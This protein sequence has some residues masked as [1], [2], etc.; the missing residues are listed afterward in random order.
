MFIILTEHWVKKW[1]IWNESFKSR[2]RLGRSKVSPE[3]TFLT[4]LLKAIFGPQGDAA[5]A[6]CCIYLGV[7]WMS[8]PQKHSH[9]ALC[10]YLR[11][12]LT[13]FWV[14]TVGISD[15]TSLSFHFA[16]CGYFRCLPQL[17]DPTPWLQSATACSRTL[18]TLSY[19][20]PHFCSLTATSN[21]MISEGSGIGRELPSL[22]LCLQDSFEGLLL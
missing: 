17:W 18:C 5:H 4:G 9:F 3:N 20:S 14:P 2:L 11:C 22:P 15:V 21:L 13:P 1:V 7:W 19:S 8:S 12:L 10:G 16:L 6:Y